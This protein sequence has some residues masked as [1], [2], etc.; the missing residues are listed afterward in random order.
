M[1]DR[2][3]FIITAIIA[4]ISGYV[5]GTYRHPAV[6]RRTLE[7]LS[8]TDTIIVKEPMRVAVRSVRTDT[9]FLPLVTADTAAVVLPVE[10]AEYAGD[11]FR[12]WV[13]GYRPSL[14]SISFARHTT[15]LRP[16]ASR[17]SFGIQAGIGLTPAG[18][19]PYLGIGLQY[20]FRL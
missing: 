19:Q 9:V 16:A 1:T 3:K 6:E 12:A 7:V 14:D 10:Q 18:I 4:A 2:I 13:S 5:A 17:F 20:R 8:R 11:G 15:T